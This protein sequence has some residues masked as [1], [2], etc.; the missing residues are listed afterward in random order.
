MHNIVKSKMLLQIAILILAF[1]IHEVKL[2]DK[3]NRINMK[4]QW[5]A[6]EILLKNPGRPQNLIIHKHNSIL[7]F[8]F[9]ILE[10]YLDTGFQIATYKMETKE[11]S[12]VPGLVGACAIAIDQASGEVYLGGSEGIYKYKL[13]SQTVEL[14][15]EKD[16]NI[17]SLFFYKYL[18]YISYPEQK[19]YMKMGNKFTKV[20]EFQ[21]FEV[22][23]FY[24]SE[25]MIYFS[26]KT[27]LY[28]FDR[29]EM[30]LTVTVIKEYITVRQITEDNKGVV[31]A[32]TNLGVFSLDKKVEGIR[33]FVDS[34][35]IHGIAFD[36]D[37]HVTM[38]DDEGIF[39]LVSSVVQCNS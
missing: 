12:V 9:T 21:N 2:E 35:D 29:H 4:G 26:N 14:Y 11:Y 24:A 10:T 20:K 1:N 22:D 32:C 19:L 7:F 34:K 17:W 23:Q 30:L 18:F 33:L 16:I 5:Y 36:K 8:S 3:C 6:K 28:R 25:N 37:N 27:G 38:S 39:K 15:A 13:I 31:Y